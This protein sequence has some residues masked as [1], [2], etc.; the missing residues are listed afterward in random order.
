VRLGGPLSYGGRAEHRPQ[1]GDGAAPD[2]ATVRR[3]VRL[4]LAIGAAAT[5]LCAAVA[6]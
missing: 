4:S 5:L 1:L 2:S 3:A 6:R